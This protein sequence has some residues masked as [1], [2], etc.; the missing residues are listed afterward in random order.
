MNK[1]YFIELLILLVNF[2]ILFLVDYFIF[3]ELLS[4]NKHYFKY[5]ILIY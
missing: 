2:L 3:I 5:I 1:Y 4:I